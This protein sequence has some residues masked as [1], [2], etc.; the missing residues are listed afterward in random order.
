VNQAVAPLWLEAS[1]NA[2]GLRPRREDLVQPSE[3]LAPQNAEQQRQALIGAIDSCSTA[4]K[5]MPTTI[6]DPRRAMQR[7]RQTCEGLRRGQHPVIRISA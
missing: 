1:T 7:Q 4:I 5:A 6:R 2:K 3:R